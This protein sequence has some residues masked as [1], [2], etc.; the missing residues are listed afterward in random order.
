MKPSEMRDKSDDELRELEASLRDELLR[1]AVA[2][3]TRR[4]NNPSQVRKIKRDIA[5][6]KTILRARELGKETSP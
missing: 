2:R 4:P 3:A 1:A 6:A 5:R